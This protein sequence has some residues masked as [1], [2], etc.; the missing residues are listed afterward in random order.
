LDWKKAFLSSIELKPEQQVLARLL[1]DENYESKD[2]RVAAYKRETGL[3]RATYFRI[4]ASLPR[5]VTGG[6]QKG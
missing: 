5:R 4:K 3:S 1:G 6:T 2:A